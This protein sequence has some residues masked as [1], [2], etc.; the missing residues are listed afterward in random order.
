MDV[1]V[2]PK[3]PSR[4]RRILRE[5]P[6]RKLAF[7]LLMMIVNIGVVLFVHGKTVHRRWRILSLGSGTHGISAIATLDLLRE[8]LW[9]TPPW[10]WSR[11]EWTELLPGTREPSRITQWGNYIE[12]QRALEALKDTLGIPPAERDPRFSLS[13]NGECLLDGSPVVDGWGHSF[14]L[15]SPGPVHK[16]G[17]DV[18]SLGPT[19][20]DDPAGGGGDLL[21]G[22]DTAPR[23]SR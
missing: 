23:T 15:A 6:R 10:E 17:W 16:H 4:F 3:P 19:G 12:T 22:E 11:D 8:N 2:E 1:H 18:Y 7:V 13:T 5:L 20:I 9:P 21:V 14:I